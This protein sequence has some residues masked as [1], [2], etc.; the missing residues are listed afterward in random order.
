MTSTFSIEEI[1]HSETN[2]GVHMP[3]PK[4]TKNERRDI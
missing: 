1:L 2:V 3:P 4:A